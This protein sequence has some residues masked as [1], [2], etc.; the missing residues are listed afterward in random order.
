MREVAACIAAVVSD[1]NSEAG[2][3][4]VR[5]RVEAL[6]SRTSGENVAVIS[7]LTPDQKYVVSFLDTRL[8]SLYDPVLP[9]GYGFCVIDSSGLV[10]FHT[11]DEKNLDEH[12][13]EECNMDKRLR[14][15][16]QSRESEWLSLQYLGGS[17]RGR[18]P[19]ARDA[20]ALEQR[21][22]A[23]TG[24]TTRAVYQGWSDLRGTHHSGRRGAERFDA[25][26]GKAVHQI[27]GTSDESALVARWFQDRVRQRSR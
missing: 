27:V 11:D 14:A 23:V 3:A 15:A 6:T 18:H 4:T 21:A 5:E 19:V 1:V 24:R 25:A 26:R 10:L 13:F 22:C 9:A 16:V 17:Q 2:L 8:L 12:F 7:K 20:A